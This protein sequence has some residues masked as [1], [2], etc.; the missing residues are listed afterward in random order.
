MEWEADCRL[1]LEHRFKSN[2]QSKKT[3]WYESQTNKI[4]MSFLGWLF[5]RGLWAH[6]RSVVVYDVQD[7]DE[8]PASFGGQAQ[9]RGRRLLVSHRI[10]SRGTAGLHFLTF[11][12]SELFNMYTGVS[13]SDSQNVV[14]NI[15]LIQGFEGLNMESSKTYEVPL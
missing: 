12:S 10:Q 8:I 3:V 15:K 7:K 9:T 1:Q 4:N 2:C 13:V 6:D 5:S 11:F 14:K